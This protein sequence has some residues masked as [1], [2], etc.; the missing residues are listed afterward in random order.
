MVPT[1]KLWLLHWNTSIL[2]F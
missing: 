2:F 1:T